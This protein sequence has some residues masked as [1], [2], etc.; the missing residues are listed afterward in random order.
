MSNGVAKR[1]AYLEA[2]A[3]LIA[4]RQLQRAT[5]RPCDQTR[6]VKA[7]PGTTGMA[8]PRRVTAIER[9]ADAPL[10][11]ACQPGTVIADAHHQIVARRAHVDRYQRRIGR[12]VAQ[13]V[14]DD[15]LDQ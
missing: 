1:Q 13:R 6:Q 5:V 14:A 7:E 4:T 2:G 12:R 10:L 8:S 15:V 11:L 9:L 3:R